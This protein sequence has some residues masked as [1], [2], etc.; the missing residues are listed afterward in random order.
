[1]NTESLTDQSKSGNHPLTFEV[2]KLFHSE[3]YKGDY[4]CV[5]RWFEGTLELVRLVAVPNGIPFDRT[6]RAMAPMFNV[7][8]TRGGVTNPDSCKHDSFII[9]KTYGEICPLCGSDTKQ[10]RNSMNKEP[11]TDQSKMPFGKHK[12][13]LM[14]SVPMKYLRWLLEQPWIE[15]W[16][17]IAAYA[18]QRVG[19]VAKPN[20]TI[21]DG[22]LYDANGK[23][24]GFACKR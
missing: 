5:N 2:G 11:L 22:I 18:R 9:T 10:I 1:M 4:E 19:E 3:I 16:P 21:R 15:Q 23:P 14:V 13:A 24:C 17:A 8:E 6:A 7:Q 20:L 12:G